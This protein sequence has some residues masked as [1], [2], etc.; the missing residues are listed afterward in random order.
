MNILFINHYSGPATHSASTRTAYLSREWA[1][2]GHQVTVVV[3]SYS[4]F[5]VID[6]VITGEVTKGQSDGVE[7]VWLKTPR[8]VGNGLG[9]MKNTFWFVAQLFRQLPGITKVA[10]PDVVIA[11][12]TYLFDTI[13]AWWISK[14]SRGVFIREIRDLWP[15]TLIE[16]SGMSRWHPFAL[17]LAMVESFSYRQADFVVSTLPCA[18]VHM[19]KGGLSPG[20]FVYIPNGIDV[21]DWVNHAEAIP[22]E[23]QQLLSELQLQKRFIVGYAGGHGLANSL[24]DLIS[25]ASRLRD[26]KISFVLVGDGPE[27]VSLQNEVARLGL[28]NV[29]FLPP[30]RKIT[31]PNLLAKMDALYI[32]WPRNSIYRFGISPN[33]LSDYLMA[34]RPVIHAV[35]AANDPV[36]ESGSGRTVPPN[37][38]E[39]LA[40][41]IVELASL[42][43]S[44]RMAMGERGREYALANHDYR[45]LAQKFLSIFDRRPK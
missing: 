22:D 7:Y 19:Q 31:V 23:H 40:D 36:A 6:P 37:C 13:P 12:S 18:E 24:N 16:L 21:L 42:P 35:E 20:K 15:L 9:R 4:P 43:L 41:A 39:A 10:R 3:A 11:G 33:K 26:Q 34:A 25:A 8:Y 44:E 38:P 32:G 45:V 5:N 30:V 2:L 28:E 29:H 1:K 17:L 14:R 27:K